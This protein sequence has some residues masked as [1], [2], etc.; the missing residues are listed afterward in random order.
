M[1][2][3]R[4]ENK[5]SLKPTPSK[6]LVVESTQKKTPCFTDPSTGGLFFVAAMTFVDKY[7]NDI[8]N[9]KMPLDIHPSLKLKQPPPA[10]LMMTWLGEVINVTKVESSDFASTNRGFIEI[11]S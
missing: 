11:G 4:G 5:K 8:P 6:H 10:I 1:S 3:N 9:S 2:P 7:T